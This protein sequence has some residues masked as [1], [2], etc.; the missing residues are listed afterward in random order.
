MEQAMLRSLF[1][2]SAFILVLLGLNSDGFSQDWPQ[3]RGPDRTAVLSDWR[4]PENWP[5]RLTQVWKVTVGEG[6]S[7]PVVAGGKVYLHSRKND[8]EVVRAI[9]LSTGKQ[10]WMRENDAS[11]KM[12]PAATGHGK[13]PKSTPVVTGGIK[14]LPMGLAAFFRVSMHQT[15]NFYGEETLPISFLKRRHCTGLACRQL[16]FEIP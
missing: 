7:S 16:H 5:D 13:G 9:F 8:R 1:R 11:Y 10:L 4:G 12:H 2:I 14:S 6:H 3:W 15:G